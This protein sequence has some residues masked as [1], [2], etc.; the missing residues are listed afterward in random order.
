VSNT[1]LKEL[2]AIENYKKKNKQ[3]NDK[4][5]THSECVLKCGRL[6]SKARGDELH[7]K[8]AL[9]KQRLDA[10]DD[11]FLSALRSS[12]KGRRQRRR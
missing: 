4:T 11:V 10:K 8:K 6:R 3:K 5:T 7:Q 9:K 1:A 2:V 12:R